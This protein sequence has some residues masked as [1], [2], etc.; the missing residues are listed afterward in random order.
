MLEGKSVE[1]KSHHR[2]GKVEAVHS[3]STQK[4]GP[5][6]IQK[7]DMIA[8]EKRATPVDRTLFCRHEIKYR[9]Y[10]SQAAAVE[11]FIR[12][13]LQLDRYSKLRRDKQYPIVS[14]YLDSDNLLLCKQTLTGH[15]NRFKLRIRS[16]TDEPGYPRFF[17]IKRRMN[18]IIIKNRARVRDE[19]VAT[20]LSGGSLPP[21]D[22]STDENTI[23]QFQLYMNNIRAKPMILIRYMRQ[24]YEDTSHNKV[25]VTFDRKLC[26]KVTREPRVLMNSQGWQENP[27][28]RGGVIL[29]IK[30]TA[31][32]PAWLSRLA[33][34]LN[35]RQDSFSKYATSVTD[36]Y[37]L[38]FCSP[39]LLVSNYG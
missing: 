27:V 4:T 11:Q 10:E 35:L 14:L 15:K 32:Y 9:I 19:D 12:P 28:S 13:Y 6:T 29:E 5:T 17:E 38:G 7:S 3:P 31:R 2:T 36:A 30:F 16:Y 37:S 24:A 33:A 20:L 21:Q 25:R 1:Q 34:C 22:Y 39:Q 23:N 8:A 26:Y 18:T